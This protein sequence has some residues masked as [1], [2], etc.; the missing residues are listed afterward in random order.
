[1][2]G[3]SVVING[4]A[5]E[6][7]I[8]GEAISHRGNE[9]LHF[10]EQ[11]LHVAYNWLRITDQ[12]T[13]Y[14]WFEYKGI[15]VWLNGYISNYKELSEK[16]DIPLQTTCDT[17][18]LTKFMHRFKGDRLDELNG[19]FAV[20]YYDGV[21]IKAFTDRY[22]IKQLYQYQHNQT[23]YICSEIK[24]I[25]AIAH[26]MELDPWA[27]ADYRH[28]L[29]VMTKHTLYKGITR[30]RCLPFPRPDKIDIPYDQA[31]LRLSELLTASITRN[32][33]DLPCGVM[34]SGGVDSGII[35]KYLKPDY[36]FSMD[37]DTIAH[38]ETQNIKLN[39]QGIHYGMICNEALL[40]KY[41]IP[42]IR[43]NDDPR[44]GSCYTNY[45]L[46]E[47]ASNFCKVIYSGAGGDELFGGFPH[48]KNKPIKDI[49]K[50]TDHTAPLYRQITHDSYDWLFLKGV[51]TVEDRTSG[52]FT[53]ETRYPLLDNDFVNFA[54]SLPDDYLKDKRI[55]K[56]ISGL[57]LSV[58]NSPKK[59][60][61]NPYITNA[62]WTTYTTQTGLTPMAT[63]STAPPL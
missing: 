18:L 12:T 17:E 11:T 42:A 22:G 24:G 34:L 31:K 47:M 9:T 27:V 23:T 26:K 15:S 60:W 55:L 13:P 58:L 28:S 46:T 29:G 53:M 45:A 36:S 57:S 25:K 37:Y 10:S 14:N 1:M 8:M 32:R 44:V 35:A 40:D 20:V 62:Q 54:L 56:D 43:C 63:L 38:S 30:V 5:H 16:Y 7:K 21:S 3:I 39:S 59:G 2:C 48:R 51:L 50:R 19:F 49:I 6:A 52:A 33:T 61:S 41:L 4:N